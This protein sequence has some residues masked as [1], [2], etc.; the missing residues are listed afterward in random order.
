VLPRDITGPREIR[1]ELGVKRNEMEKVG[2]VGDFRKFRDFYI[3]HISL[4]IY[5]LLKSNKTYYAT[6]EKHITY[7]T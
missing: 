2:Y 4:D 6:D 3:K 1:E 7:K 5:K